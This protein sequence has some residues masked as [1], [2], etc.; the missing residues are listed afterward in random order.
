[1]GGGPGINGFSGGTDITETP[2]EIEGSVTQSPLSGL[3]DAEPLFCIFIHP[4][5]AVFRINQ[6]HGRI[7]LPGY[8]VYGYHVL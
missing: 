3:P 6:K 5:D 8:V 7:E 1:M 4:L 2:A